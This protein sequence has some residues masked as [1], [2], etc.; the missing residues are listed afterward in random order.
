MM[1]IGENAKMINDM[2]RERQRALGAIR[3]QIERKAKAGVFTDDQIAAVRSFFAETDAEAV[4]EAIDCAA[5]PSLDAVKAELMKPGGDLG[6][7]YRLID[8]LADRQR[9]IIRRLSKTITQCRRL[10]AVLM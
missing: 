7:A 3:A 2:L 1:D 5:P 6:R 9:E 8:W 10:S 4:T